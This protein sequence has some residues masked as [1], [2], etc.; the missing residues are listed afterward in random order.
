MLFKICRIILRQLMAA[1]CCIIVIFLVLQPVISC[2]VR[3][4]R[5]IS[6]HPSQRTIWSLCYS[7]MWC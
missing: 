7:S 5:A 2:Q 1:C 4:H 3:M 6:L